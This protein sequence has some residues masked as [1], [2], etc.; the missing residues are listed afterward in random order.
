[1]KQ[2]LFFL[3]LV[4]LFANLSLHCQSTLIQTAHYPINPAALCPRIAIASPDSGAWIIGSDDP[5]AFGA[6]KSHRT[7]S[8]IDKN[9]NPQWQKYFQFQSNSSFG[10]TEIF[11][12]SKTLKGGLIIC[13]LTLSQA[14]VTCLDANA[15]MIWYKTLEINNTTNNFKPRTILACKD[16]GFV[17]AGD[18]PWWGITIVKL[19]KFG[20]K[21]WSKLETDF[22]EINP[23]LTCLTEGADSSIY[24]GGKYTTDDNNN[25]SLPLLL[26][27]NKN[28]TIAWKKAYTPTSTAFAYDAQFNNLLIKNGKMYA[29]IIDNAFY[30]ANLQ[31][32]GEVIWT[33]KINQSAYLSNYDSKANSLSE[34]DAGRLFA[35]VKDNCV[36]FDTTGQV[37]YVMSR[38]AMGKSSFVPLLNKRFLKTETADFWS[39][40]IP[41]T[42]YAYTLTIN[43]VL[44]PETNRCFFLP[45][46]TTTSFSMQD[47]VLSSM[48]TDTCKI[49][50]EQVIAS[51]NYSIQLQSGCDLTAGISDRAHTQSNITVFPNPFSTTIELKATNMFVTGY[52]L[53]ATDGRV[54]KKTVVL[55]D[56]EKLT[57]DL[58]DLSGGIYFLEVHTSGANIQVIKLQRTD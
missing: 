27:L 53:K 46:F 5:A 25:L 1:M 57:L 2:S 49:N 55:S 48:A 11:A 52:C 4:S 31:T 47:S 13:G 3:V 34:S 51:V 58:T 18:S 29:T 7:I 36:S 42:S 16:S 14:F 26:K 10:S 54:L 12:A 21:V 35:C 41:Y 30:I 17:I 9:G 20:N 28:G 8:K 33:K 15:T 32:D 19:D 44:Q 43:N 6:H 37:F 38:S 39:S 45:T 24:A 56:Q 23:S 50:S 22:I 40:D